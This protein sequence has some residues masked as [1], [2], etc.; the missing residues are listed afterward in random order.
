LKAIRWG[1]VGGGRGAFI[2]PAHR[3]AARLDGRYELIAGA[4]SSDAQRALESARDIGIAPDRSYGSY[5]SM[6]EAESRRDDGIEAVSIVTPNDSH[7]EIAMTFLAHGIHVICDK[8]LVINREQGEKLRA[9]AAKS[10]CL[11]AVTYHYR[12]YPMVRQARA[13]C[14]K[15]TLGAIRLIDVEY[16][17]DW[18]STRIEASGSSQAAWR[19]DPART[20]QVGSLGDI[21]TH[22]Y[23]LCRYI[24][25]LQVTGIRAELNSFVEHRAV[26]DDARVSL[27]FAQGAR[28]RLWASQVAIGHD[29]ELSIRVYGDQGS[30]GWRHTDPGTL[31]YTPLGSPTVRLAAGGAGTDVACTRSRLPVG[32]PE[33][34]Y[35]AFAT[36][37]SEIAQAIRAVQ[38]RDRT[39]IPAGVP[40]LETGLEAV[41]FVATALESHGAGGVWL[42]SAQP[43]D[44]SASIDT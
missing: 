14:T 41:G 37:Y 39:R 24:T 7:A 30:L 3:I 21:G 8:P 9:A 2:G 33:G 25:E 15:G 40:D 36:V 6:A 38:A 26:D 22:A 31:L 35:E 4:L 1:M 28:G 19:T 12:G 43:G 11:V 32:H 16:L 29:N 42:A 27:R 17:Q 23:D 44:R 20:G 5:Q 18:L 10:G 34:F 13:L